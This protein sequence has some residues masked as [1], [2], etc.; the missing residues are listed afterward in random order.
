ML[1]WEWHTYVLVVNMGFWR[2]NFYICVV[3]GKTEGCTFMEPSLINSYPDQY[4]TNGKDI[5]N[6]SRYVN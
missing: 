6:N 4:H 5:K 3:I 2:L 1:P